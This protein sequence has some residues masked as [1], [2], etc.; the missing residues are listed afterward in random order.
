MIDAGKLGDFDPTQLFHL[1]Y[2]VPSMERAVA[3]WERMGATLVVAAAPDPIQ[4][5]TCA[6]LSFQHAVLI[7]LVSPLSD[8]SPVRGRLAKGGG[9]DHICL[10]ADDVPSDVLAAEARGAMVVVQPCY[11]AVF[12]R[13][14]AFVLTRGG[15]VVEFMSRGPVGKA[16]RDPLA[17][18]IRLRF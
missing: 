8:D 17:D 12:D 15:L 14:L 18:L 9:L 11:G 10:F 7:E 16:N 5:V 13:E 1:G 3:V 4:R 2:V 6:L